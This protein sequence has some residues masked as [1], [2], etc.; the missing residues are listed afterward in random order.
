MFGCNFLQVLII[1]VIVGLKAWDTNGPQWMLITN[2][3]GA[4]LVGLVLGD[5]PTG[6]YVGAT[7]GLMS[8]GV[9]GL[10]GASVPNYFIS[11]IIATVIAIKSTGG[12]EMGLTIGLPVGMLYVYLDVLQK[13][14][15]GVFARNAEAAIDR[16]EYEKVDL[17]AWVGEITAIAKN[18]LPVFLV[19]VFGQGLV[20]TL[21]NI[22][23]E[24]LYKGLTLAGKILPVT[25]MAIL[26]NY[27]PVKRHF[28]Y[29][30]IGFV[31]Y[32]YVGIPTLGVGILGAA[33]AYKAWL[34]GQNKATVQVAGGMEDE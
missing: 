8:L 31:A 26:L 22:M 13:L 27:M 30:L 33:F 32:A 20:E 21:V 4:V 2:V 28:T 23:P 15:C 3:G 14:A 12:Y 19:F 10:G 1:L 18:V 9:V 24:F 11:T 16:G 6:L 17:W 34:D 5:M 7:L 29:L 25:G